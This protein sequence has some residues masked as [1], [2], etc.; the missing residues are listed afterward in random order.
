[1]S[2]NSKQAPFGNQIFLTPESVREGH[3]GKLAIQNFEAIFGVSLRKKPF[4]SIA[5]RTLLTSDCH[6][7]PFGREERRV[8]CDRLD[9]DSELR[10]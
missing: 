1:M 10:A 5:F 8:G 6:G 2:S 4:S 3:L 7:E 9:R